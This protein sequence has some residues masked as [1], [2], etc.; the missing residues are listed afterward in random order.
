MS[1][2]FTEK[3]E[4]ALNKSVKIA[5]ALGHT[6]IGTEHILSALAD[7]E[8][9]CA[10][11][12][13]KKNGISKDKIS[14]AIKKKNPYVSDVRIKRRGIDTLIIT[15]TEDKP[16][17]YMEFGGRYLVLSAEL[18]VLDEYARREDMPFADISPIKIDHVRNAELGKVPVFEEEFRADALEYVSFLTKIN[19][20]PLAGCITS[21]DFTLRFDIRMVYKD[22]YEIRFGSPENFEKKLSLVARTIAFLEDPANN[23]SGAKGIIRAT[24][25]GETSFEPTGAIT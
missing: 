3:A 16:N 5:E 2:R 13:L 15:V 7:D 19:E 17:F 10:A 11:L 1:D 4:N 12:V 6:Y 14:D 23:Y 24:V 8:L 21:A 20:S 18:R 9:S 22:K 25:D